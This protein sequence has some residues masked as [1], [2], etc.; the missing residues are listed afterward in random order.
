LHTQQVVLLPGV[1]LLLA[2][3]HSWVL[4]GKEEENQGTAEEEGI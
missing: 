2:Y 1:I 3:L 4:A